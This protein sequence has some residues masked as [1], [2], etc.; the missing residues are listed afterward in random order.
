MSQTRPGVSHRTLGLKQL[1][2]HG[3]AGSANP[4]TIACERRR[5]QALIEKYGYGLK[6]LFNMDETGL[7]Y[8]HAPFFLLNSNRPYFNGRMPPRSRSC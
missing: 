1:K 2:R 4:E 6:D 3:E 5:L 7:F 8:G